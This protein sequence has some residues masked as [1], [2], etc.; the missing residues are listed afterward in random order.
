VLVVSLLAP[1]HICIFVTPIFGTHFLTDFVQKR[2]CNGTL[3]ILCPPA[4]Q[5]PVSERS[6]AISSLQSQLDIISNQKLAAY[7]ISSSITCGKCLIMKED[8]CSM[9]GPPKQ[10]CMGTLPLQSPFPNHV[11]C[12]NAW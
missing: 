8:D 4:P 9:V 1:F 7:N 11:T 12:C 6:S 5:S 3:P 10:S 2:R